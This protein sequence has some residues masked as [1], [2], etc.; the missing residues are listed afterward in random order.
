[1]HPVPQIQ[2][3]HSMCR[4]RGLAAQ[5]GGAHAVTHQ[6]LSTLPT[7]SNLQPRARETPGRQNPSMAHNTVTEVPLRG[8]AITF[9]SE[10]RPQPCA[11]CRNGL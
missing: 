5:A 11:R 7:V 9:V 1:M 10:R 6:A 3:G 2:A 8:K 4:S